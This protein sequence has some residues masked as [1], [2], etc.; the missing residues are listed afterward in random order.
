MNGS[1]RGALVAVSRG[2]GQEAAKRTQASSRDGGEAGATG[3][4]NS[5]RWWKKRKAGWSSA[6]GADD[7]CARPQDFASATQHTLAGC[8]VCP[9]AGLC[10]STA[11]ARVL[12]ARDTGRMLQPGA[13]VGPSWP[14][15]ARLGCVG[16]TLHAACC[17]HAPGPEHA[18]W[19]PLRQNTPHAP[20]RHPLGADTDRLPPPRRA[21]V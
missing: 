17:L 3:V 2:R 16:S 6:P 4:I 13:R 7:G 12:E 1:A 20:L 19:R 11:T 21:P 9:A 18:R 5:A 10:P 14:G 15:L 8:H